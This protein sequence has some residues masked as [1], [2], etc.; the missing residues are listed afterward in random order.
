MLAATSL[1]F[2]AL[3]FSIPIYAEGIANY[4]N[5]YGNHQFPDKCIEKKVVVRKSI[6][7]L[8][9]IL[10]QIQSSTVDCCSSFNTPYENRN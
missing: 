1:I 4:Y 5:T 10:K 3:S 7:C 6:Q 8:D 9:E 2:T